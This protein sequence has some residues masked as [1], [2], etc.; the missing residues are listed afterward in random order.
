MSVWCLVYIDTENS[1]K[2]K[3]AHVCLSR[4]LTL[5]PCTGSGTQRWNYYYIPH[6]AH[7]STCILLCAIGVRAYLSVC[8]FLFALLLPSSARHGMAW[9]EFSCDIHT[10]TAYSTIRVY[11]F[12]TLMCLHS[13]T[14]TAAPEPPAAAAPLNMILSTVYTLQNEN[15]ACYQQFQN[16]CI[17]TPIKQSRATEQASSAHS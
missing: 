12:N 6:T 7:R 9:H 14:A 8:V 10:Y 11:I 5:F 1:T 2:L 17:Y 3:R 16:G 15:C 4:S 13:R